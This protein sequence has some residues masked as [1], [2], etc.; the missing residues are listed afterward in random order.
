VPRQEP[1][2]DSC[3]ARSDTPLSLTSNHAA[4]FV[5]EKANDSELIS[6]ELDFPHPA[7]S[8]EDELRRNQFFIS[9]LSQHEYSKDDYVSPEGIACS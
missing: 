7:G 4:A 5:D 2:A 6:E 9:H 8:W 1:S 3:V